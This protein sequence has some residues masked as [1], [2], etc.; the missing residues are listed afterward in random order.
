MRPE[1]TGREVITVDERVTVMEGE[2]KEG[3]EVVITLLGMRTEEE[4]VTRRRYEVWGIGPLGR[5]GRWRRGR[6]GGRQLD[7][8]RKEG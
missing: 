8:W 6:K 4:N 1:D 3:E 2:G 5:R 7:R